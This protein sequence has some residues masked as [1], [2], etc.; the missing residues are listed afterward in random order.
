IGYT[1]PDPDDSD[2]VAAWQ[3]R[4]I[5]RDDAFVAHF[6]ALARELG[7]AIAITYLEAR[8]DGPRNSVS[9]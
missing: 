5:G 2:G 9:L 8:P 6:R 1:L 4:A 3:A 7:M